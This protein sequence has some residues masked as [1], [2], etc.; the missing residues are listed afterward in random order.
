MS[1]KYRIEKDRLVT[2]AATILS[3]ILTARIGTSW[4]RKEDIELALEVARELIYQ[5]EEDTNE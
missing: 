2:T 4:N 1:D 5:V 3:G